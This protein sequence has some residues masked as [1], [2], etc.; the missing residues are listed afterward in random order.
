L[1]LAIIVIVHRSGPS[2]S[3]LTCEKE[4][5]GRSGFFATSAK[6]TGT[7][8]NGEVCRQQ[9]VTINAAET[10]LCERFHTDCGEAS[11]ALN[12]TIPENAVG[13]VDEVIQ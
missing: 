1:Q 2:F 4:A 3:G 7:L 12:L 9:L 6:N 10:F 13:P 5:A 11:K 8:R